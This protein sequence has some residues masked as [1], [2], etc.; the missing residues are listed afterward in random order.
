MSESSTI[1]ALAS[2]LRGR[3]AALAPGDRLP[4]NRE[5]VRRHG[6]SPVTVARAVAVL[7]AEGAVVT[8]PG[9]GT[10]V[11]ARRPGRDPAGVDTSWQSVVLGDRMVETHAVTDLLDPPP[12]GAITMAGGY[13]HRSLQP[14][15]AL[16]DPLAR[17]SRRPDAW[18]RAPT[19]GLE[20]LRS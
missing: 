4:S 20:P 8:R 3:I 13:L 6:V 1:E 19:A 2:N 10:F 12:D 11:A 16:S 5:L 14:T 7:A 17:A 18:D 15:R 9:S